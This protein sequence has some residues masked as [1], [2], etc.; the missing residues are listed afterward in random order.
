MNIKLKM[1]LKGEVI[2]SQN[3][4]AARTASEFSFSDANKEKQEKETEAI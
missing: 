1:L 2:I 4:V 3:L